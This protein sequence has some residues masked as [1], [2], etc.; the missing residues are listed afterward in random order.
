MVSGAQGLHSYLTYYS[1][2]H[3]SFNTRN[4]RQRV[5]FSHCWGWYWGDVTAGPPIR[6]DGDNG[7]HQPGPGLD[8][9]SGPIFFS[10]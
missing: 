2:L 6:F 3:Q 4:Q 5:T 9:W 1:S 8:M 10:P 7:V